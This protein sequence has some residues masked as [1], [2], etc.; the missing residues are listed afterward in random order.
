MD[1]E[2]TKTAASIIKIRLDD[3]I[4]DAR[5]IDIVINDAICFIELQLFE[6][7]ELKYD[8]QKWINRAKKVQEECLDLIIEINDLKSK[9]K[10]ENQELKNKIQE[11]LNEEK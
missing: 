8:M 6:V 10:K 3:L 11:L 7:V 5:P 9:H 4:H 2:Q 1:I